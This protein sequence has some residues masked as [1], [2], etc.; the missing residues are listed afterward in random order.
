MN[1]LDTLMNLVGDTPVSEQ[2]SMAINNHTHN[3]VTTDEIEELKRKIKLLLELVGD[4]SVSE[5]IHMAISN[6]E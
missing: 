5:Q 6:I 1:D 4:T 3:Y 2:I